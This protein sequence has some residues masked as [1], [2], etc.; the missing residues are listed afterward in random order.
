MKVHSSDFRVVDLFAGCGGLSLGLLNAG[1]NVIAGFDHWEVAIETYRCNFNHQA[2][3][4]DLG[5][6]ED[7]FEIFQELTPDIIVGG[8]PCQD[9]SSAGKRNENLGQ[10]NLTIS[11]AEIVAA[12]QPRF[13]MMENVDRFT[14]STKYE[15]A[16]QIFKAADYGLS[17][18]IL[19]ASLCGVPQK[20]KRFFWIGELNGDDKKIEPYLER[21]LSSQS[22]TVEQ[23]FTK[24]EKPLDIEHYYRHPRSYKRRGVFSIDEPSPTVRGVNRPI[25]KTYKSHPGDSALISSNVRPLTT[26]ERSQLQTFPDTFSFKGS[27]TDLEQMIGN[28]VPVK[29]AE[30]VGGCLARYIVDCTS[31]PFKAMN[32]QLVQITREFR[33]LSLL[34]S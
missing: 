4:L 32:D 31:R 30:Y 17:E 27:K 11:F 25:P 22:M 8:P 15:E 3:V 9:F 12:I 1:F 10:G 21:G 28:A 5:S 7:N 24:I 13:F 18:K 14:K 29:L 34:E 2:F 33:Q 20:R 16:K 19:D 23:Y 6:L 26:L